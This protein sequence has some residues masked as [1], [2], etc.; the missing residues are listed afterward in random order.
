[1]TTAFAELFSDDDSVDIAAASTA[2]T[3]SPT[4]PGRQLVHD[5]QAE[6][7][8]V[9]RSR[10]PRQEQPRAGRAVQ[11]DADAEEQQELHEDRRTRCSTSASRAWPSDSAQR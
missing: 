4:T 2:A 8:V 5:E 9:A 6:H 10:R 7:L 11:P 3:S 1:M